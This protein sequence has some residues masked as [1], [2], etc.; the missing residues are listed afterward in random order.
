MEISTNEF[1]L[2]S[3]LVWLLLSA[4]VAFLVNRPVRKVEVVEADYSPET[5]EYCRKETTHQRLENLET[6][7]LHPFC[8]QCNWR[9]NLD[10]TKYRLRS[11]RSANPAK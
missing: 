6:G 9:V 8:L 11:L 4:L 3:A 7:E 2:I 10:V 5:C 1:V